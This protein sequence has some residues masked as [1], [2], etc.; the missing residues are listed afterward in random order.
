MA[1]TFNEKFLGR[2]YA[3]ATQELRRTT[4]F[5]HGSNIIYQGMN[6]PN[7]QYG[8]VQIPIPVPFDDATDITAASTAP[9]GQDIAATPAEISL[10]NW[11]EVAFHL[12]DAEVATIEAGLMPMQIPKAVDALARTIVKSVTAKHVGIYNHVGTAGTTPFASTAT[13]ATEARKLLNISGAPL[14]DRYMMVGDNAEANAINLAIFQK[15]NESGGSD[16]LTNGVIGRRIGFDWALESYL[17]DFTGGTLNNGTDKLAL[18]NNAA[19]AVGD[20]SVPMDSP[21]LTGTLVVG[22][23][24][25]VAGDDQQYV[26]TANAAASSNAIASVSFSPPAKVAW[27]NNAVVTFVASHEV[28][29]IAMQREA[30]AFASRPTAPAFEG[31]NEFMSIP[32]PMS[33][34]VLQMEMSREHYQTKVAF[35]CLWGSVLAQPSSAVRVLG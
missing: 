12:T 1:N 24:F 25:T 16:T 31:G 9:A 14:R 10:D 5:L 7:R 18:I 26:V 20:T 23:L 29:A 6:Q 19:V 3:L 28:A 35:S 4:H 34:L 21:T 32:D 17:P 2:V 30:F 11:K 15:V 27:A 33:G 13:I 8:T 22:D